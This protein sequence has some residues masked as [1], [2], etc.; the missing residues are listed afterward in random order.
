[1]ACLTAKEP[2]QPS[3]RT[4]ALGVGV[5]SLS[6]ILIGLAPLFVG[7]YVDDYRL[8]LSEAGFVQTVDQAGGVAGAIAS[9]YL[10]RP[11][12]WKMLLV[13]SGMIAMLANSATGFVDTLDALCVVRFLA[14]FGVTVIMAVSICLLALSPAPDRTFGIGLAAGTLLS[15]AAIWLFHEAQIGLGPRVG[16]WSTSGWLALATALA[17]ML[18]A[19]LGGGRLLA[20]A[21]DPAHGLVPGNAIGRSGLAALLLFG[22]GL[23]IVYGFI[24]RAG[25]A[26]GLSSADVAAAL[27]IGYLL[28]AAGSLVPAVF[29]AEQ[30]R[31]KW[32]AATTLLNV[33]SVW[34]VYNAATVTTATIAFAVFVTGWNMGLAYYMGLI[35]ANDPSERYTRMMYS[36]NV[37]AQ[38]LGPAISSLAL[39][40]ASLAS[41]FLISPVP[42]IAAA[43][44][45]IGI[46]AAKAKPGRV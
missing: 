45:V 44:L 40:H 16:I 2:D 6:V 25:I 31:L 29:G 32:I 4:L 28:S 34:A 42:L 26:N 37:A 5:Y 14:G 46:A 27:S 17:I 13:I 33:G 20:G 36:A 1:M 30:G 21:G 35:A 38:S 3:F 12:D 24:E 8:T 18:P 23:N 9:Y 39:T 15:S 7:A 22:I 10:M 11:F 43:L 41:I 19:G